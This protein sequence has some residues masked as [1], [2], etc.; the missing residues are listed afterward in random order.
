MCWSLDFFEEYIL[1]DLCVERW[2]MPT[3][4]LCIRNQT[5]LSLEKM[6]IKMYL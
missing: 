3:K 1:D 2:A 4:G 5:V 6:R